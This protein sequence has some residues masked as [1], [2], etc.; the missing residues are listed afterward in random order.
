MAKFAVINESN[1]VEN[2]IVADLVST[3]EEVTGL[4]CVEINENTDCGIG[5]SYENS[6]FVSQNPAPESVVEN[7]TIVE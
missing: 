4:T 3:A 2:I 7:K 6:T 5:Y 1:I